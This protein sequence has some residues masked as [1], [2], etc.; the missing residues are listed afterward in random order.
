MNQLCFIKMKKEKEYVWWMCSQ[1][2]GE[3]VFLWVHAEA[4][5]HPEGPTSQY[6]IDQYSIE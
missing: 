1:V 6:C 3:G 4:S 2:W 5:L